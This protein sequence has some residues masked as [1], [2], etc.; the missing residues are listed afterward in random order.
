VVLDIIKTRIIRGDEVMIRFGIVGAGGIAQKFA[1]DIKFVDGAVVTAVA[2]RNLDKANKFKDEYG[3]ENAFGSYEEMAKSDL[4]DAVYIATPH[5]FH[6]EQAILYMN[7]KKHVLCEKPIA[8]SNGEFEL[9][10]F[11]AKENKVLL[12]E[13]MW[14][15]FLPVT[16]LIRETVESNKLGKFKKAYLEFGANITG[17]GGD[18][19]RWFN[20]DLAGGSLLDMGVYPVAFSLNLTNKVVTNIEATATFYKTGIDVECIA[21]LTYEDG[22]TIRAVSS[23][24][25]D[26]DKPGVMEFENGTIIAENF[27]RSQKVDIAGELHE[28]PFKGDGFPYQIESFI[29]TLDKG[30]LENEIMTHDQTRKSMKLLDRIRETIGLKYP[31]EK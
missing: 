31:F 16:K 9:M 11:S 15:K 8:V 25:E 4:I 13:A 20:A 21:D 29:D 19:G 27:W 17:L 3:I 2:S 5:S 6:K 10:V 7:N 23:F 12:M 28:L 30:L 18:N 26:R 24:N 14:T 22:S 1:K